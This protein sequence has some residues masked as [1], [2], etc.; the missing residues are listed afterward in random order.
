M[1]NLNTYIPTEE[2]YNSRHK[3]ITSLAD[4]NSRPYDSWINCNNYSSFTIEVSGATSIDA[5]VQGCVNMTDV[6]GN[7][8]KPEDR[9]YSAL[10][11]INLT[12]FDIEE[13]ITK[14]GLYQI[15]SS[16]IPEVKLNVTAIE[17][18]VIIVGAGGN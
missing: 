5:T 10:K 8:L 16:G 2:F 9:K 1:Q 6:D 11:I 17:G 18:N 12:T 4:L 3:P 15:A 14:D 7:R 13:K